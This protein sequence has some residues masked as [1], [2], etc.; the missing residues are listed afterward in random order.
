MQF[1]NQTTLA[2]LIAALTAILLTSPLTHAGPLPSASALALA[3]ALPTPI[4]TPQGIFG[5]IARGAARL[6][7]K[8]AKQ[9][10]KEGVREAK[11]AAEKHERAQNSEDCKQRV[12]EANRAARSPMAMGKGGGLLVMITN[13]QQGLACDMGNPYG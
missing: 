7:P 10:G 3:L 9:G 4:P 11:K 12:K 6:G 8:A 13:M 1:T 5:L 2:T